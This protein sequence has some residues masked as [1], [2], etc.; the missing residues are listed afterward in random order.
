MDKVQLET[1][2]DKLNILLF[3]FNEIKQIV[4]SLLDTKKEVASE[5]E[6]KHDVSDEEVSEEEV[7]TEEEEEV[8]EEE[9]EVF[10]IE[11]DDITY[12]ATDEENGILY[13]MT[14]DGDV[15]EKVGII[16]E[17]EPIFS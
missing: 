15:G 17:G 14:K 12:F 5:E 11:I 10:E 2:L 3:D 16:K 7:Q 6:V 4:L 13:A 9:E 8:K 1:I